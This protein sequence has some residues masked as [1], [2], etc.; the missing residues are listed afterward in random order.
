MCLYVC[1][2][3][4]DSSNHHHQL[5]PGKAPGERGWPAERPE[6][7]SGLHQ[8]WCIKWWVKNG[9]CMHVLFKG[10]Y[11]YIKQGAFQTVRSAEKLL[12]DIWSWGGQHHPV[13]VTFKNGQTFFCRNWSC[14][15]KCETCPHCLR[16]A[17]FH[18]KIWNRVVKCI[19]CNTRE[20]RLE[21]WPL[22]I[23]VQMG[24]L[25]FF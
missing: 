9:C 6:R 7:K 17:T 8:P 22:L 5:L 4:Q 25:G 20:F 14:V 11:M 1:V 21:E 2:C 18:F 10:Q 15:H 24:S 23:R 3:L 19:N 12:S 16:F 13:F